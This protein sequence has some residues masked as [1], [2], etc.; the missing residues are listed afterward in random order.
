MKSSH[1]Y[2]TEAELCADFIEQVRALGTWDIYPECQGWDILLSRQSDG[3]QI[4]I[5]AKLKLNSIVVEQALEDDWRPD[6][7]GPDHRAVLVPPAGGNFSRKVCKYLG[8]TIL[9]IEH[10]ERWESGR[11]V[12]VP[13]IQPTLPGD[14]WRFV[15]RGDNQWHDLCPTKRLTLPDYVPDVAAGKPAPVQLTDWKI[16]AI[17]IAII[18]EQRPVT[19]ADFAALKLDHRRWLP[20]VAGWLALAPGGGAWIAGPRIPD[21]KRQHPVNYEEIKADA[22][23][24]MP[25]ADLLIMDSIE[26]GVG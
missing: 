13:E 5:E 19:R 17:K 6:Q 20:S 1:P 11:F 23:K 2:A 14:K 26:G 24:W 8:L 3:L 22:P 15:Y 12:E 9:T 25:T 4:G 21:F 7:P 10:R 18:L 16:K